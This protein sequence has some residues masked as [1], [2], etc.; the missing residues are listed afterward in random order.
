LHRRL[1]CRAYAGWR[2]PLSI[3]Y[4]LLPDIPVSKTVIHFRRPRG[5]AGR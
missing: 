3:S 1:L 5:L 4:G 2:S